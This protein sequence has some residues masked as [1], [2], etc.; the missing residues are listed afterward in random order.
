[1]KKGA[2]EDK[3]KGK[4][5]EANIYL[6]AMNESRYDQRG[7]SPDKREVH[8][9][10]RGL[11]KGLFPNAF[12][13][14][15]PDLAAG[16]PGYCNVMHADT[17]GTKTALAY[18]DWKE[19]GDASVFR[20][21][22]QDAIVMNIDDMACA[23]ATGP[24]LLSSTIGRNKHK[25]PGEIIAEV[26]AGTTEFIENLQALGIE[27]VSAGGE[28]ADVGDIVRTIDVGYT[29]FARLPR[30]KVQDIRIRAGNV[31]VGL[32]S[33]GQASY[34]KSYNS[35]IASNGL[36][37][38]RHDVLSAYYAENYPEA[39]DPDIPEELAFCGSRRLSGEFEGHRIGDLLLSPT[40]S[41]LPVIKKV[42]ETFPGRIDAIL[43]NTGG[44]HS[45]VLK[46]CGNHRIVKEQLLPV[47]PVFRLIQE[48][49]GASGHEM[50]QVF[51]MGTRLEFYVEESLAPELIKIARHFRID[52]Q[53]IG[54]VEAA[55]K[56]EV[57][58]HHHGESIH[59]G[60]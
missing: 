2:A 59:Y 49:S 20:G 31:I 14:I 60:L 22:A 18:L 4:G 12:C 34:E 45:K 33:Y 13:K 24:I 44:A 47:P 15:L 51:N 25:I 16:D 40:R 11:D 9:A 21:I 42:L 55:E 56:A 23:G 52:A 28:T 38:A 29:A 10:I 48:E 32:A 37:S 43:H 54:H 58:L 26:I 8:R 57:V 36:T 46:F 5:S 27:I 1:M 30:K 19:R 53:V 39:Y 35:G 3:K 7:V 50:F 17:A 41:F 6:W